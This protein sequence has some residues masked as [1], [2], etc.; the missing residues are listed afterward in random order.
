ML[1]HFKLSDDDPFVSRQHYLLEIA[2]IRTSSWGSEG[3]SRY[4]CREE[5][6]NIVGK[7]VIIVVT[8]FPAEISSNLLETNGLAIFVRHVCVA[9]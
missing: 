8:Y 2:S 9:L 4:D 3:R 6:G 5:V 1:V 7:T